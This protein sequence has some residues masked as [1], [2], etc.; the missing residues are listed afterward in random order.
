MQM[1]P[2]LRCA[3]GRKL[4]DH[5]ERGSEPSSRGCS[6]GQFVVE[7]DSGF[8]RPAEPDLSSHIPH[9]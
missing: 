6:S 5:G 8:Q 9:R 7:A 3:T 4:T 1:P 2:L